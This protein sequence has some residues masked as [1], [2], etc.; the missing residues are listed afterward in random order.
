[1]S[2]YDYLFKI[3]VVG[4]GAVGKT[5]ITIRFAEGRFEEHYKMTIGVDFAIKLVE[6]SGY[7]VKMQVWDT[8]G[9]ER[10]SYIRPLYYKGAMAALALFDLTNRESYDNLP[11]WFSE[12]AENCGG[13]PLMLIGNK[14]DLPDRAVTTTEAQALA[15]KMGITYFE[16]SAKNGQNVNQ[17]FEKLAGLLVTS[18]LG[19]KAVAPAEPVIKAAE[20]AAPSPSPPLITAPTVSEASMPTMSPPPR[21]P[22]VP[23]MSSPPKIESSSPSTSQPAPSPPIT[24]QPMEIPSKAPSPS[25]NEALEILRGTDEEAPSEIEIPSTPSP[26][27][28]EPISIPKHPVFTPSPQPAPKPPSPKPL[29]LTPLTLE[30]PPMPSKAPKFQESRLPFQEPPS[31]APTPPVKSVPLPRSAPAEIPFAA[32]LPSAKP[33]AEAAVSEFIAF[34]PGPIEQPKPVVTDE[35]SSWITFLKRKPREEE[36]E[37]EEPK[38]IPFLVSDI[39]PTRKKEKKEEIILEVIPKQEAQTSSDSQERTCPSCHQKVS[40]GWKFCTYCGS[41]MN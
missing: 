34:R 5:A 3:I 7:K 38:F 37:E 18:K 36:E 13:I 1:M 26:P 16:A 33:A 21:P 39:S 11:R 40:G 25:L 19:I 12:V 28:L 4:D 24:P 31:K 2:E 17:L 30:P 41:R 20:P 22:S 9:Q 23:A 15:E 32:S 6:V 14:A 10:F 29:T 27:A 8:G 35:D